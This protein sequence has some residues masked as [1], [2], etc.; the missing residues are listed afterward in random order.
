MVTQKLYS[1]NKKG[2]L[3]IP[4]ILLGIFSI[5][6]FSG[7]PNPSDLSGEIDIT[8]YSFK[9][10]TNDVL[11]DDA[12]AVIN[13]TE[14]TAGVPHGT[15][16]T[17]L[18]AN[19]TIIGANI[20]V[21]GTVQESGVS[22]NDFSEP[23]TYTVTADDGSVQEYTVTVT[24]FTPVTFSGL[25]ANGQSDVAATTELT[26]EFD[27]DPETLTAENITV[28]GATKG[29]LSGSGTTRT[30]AISDLTV[31]L[32]GD[33]VK[34][35]LSDPEGYTILQP[36][37]ETSV[38]VLDYLST[39]AGIT[40]KYVAGGTFQRDATPANTSTVSTFRMSEC[41][42]TRSQYST[43]MG[44]DPSNTGHSSSTNDP[45]QTINWYQSIA[46]CNKLSIAEGLEEVY[47]VTINGTPVDFGILNFA[48]IPTTD[49]ADWNDVSADWTATGY[50]L[51]TAMELMWAGMG[52]LE[53]ARPGDIVGG[54]NTGGYTKGYSGSTEAADGQVN[55]EDY[56]WYSGNYDGTTKPVGQKLKN[57]LGLYDVTGHVGEWAWDRDTGEASDIDTTTIPTY[58]AGELTDY[59][60]TSSGTNRV[61]RG[62]YWADWCSMPEYVIGHFGFVLAPTD[63]MSILGFR[64]VRN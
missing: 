21:N 38:H 3:L 49:D 30:L 14:I 53:D 2:R 12:V 46:F 1:G 55:I 59:R 25:S 61:V 19:F 60:G 18:I 29:T 56:A 15:D 54:I 10:S 17:A 31:P 6:I 36:S 44:A 24:Y 8:E 47:T 63:Q 62:G 40:L 37:Q 27:T 13:G 51:P 33:N 26:L 43:I 11:S 39:A 5:V 4:V 64:V 57:E 9:A 20:Q 28:T 16:I 35:E 34:V 50:R 45:V 41:E 7:C 23:V 58:P 22:A 48:D 52:G 32:D 42:I